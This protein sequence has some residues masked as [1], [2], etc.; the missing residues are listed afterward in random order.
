MLMNLSAN[1]LGLDNAATPLG[2]K[3]MRELQTLN[4]TEDTATNAM[5]TFLAMNTSSVTLIPFTVIG[6]RAI[7]GSNNPTGPLAAMILT[8][9]V[10]TVAAV[11]AVRWLSKWP[12]FAM[13]AATTNSNKRN[14]KQLPN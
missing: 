12:Q 1:M 11:I 6:Y 4:P 13:P 3:A 2:L 8:T 9:T 10:S 14:E 7:A 5:A